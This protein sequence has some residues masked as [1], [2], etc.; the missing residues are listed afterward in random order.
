MPGALPRARCVL[1]LVAS[2]LVTA[3]AAL[4]P[5]G[6]GWEWGDPGTELRWYVSGLD[7]PSTLFQLVGN[8]ALIALPAVFAVRLWPGLRP[9]PR[10]VGASLAA[11]VAI[12]A[13]QFLLP[14]GRVVSPLDALLNASGAVVAA[15]LAMRASRAW[16]AGGGVAPPGS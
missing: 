13:L 5:K 14:I 2:L 9:L 8:L 6:S 16:P 12:E 10:L 7:S 4:R 15:A 11:G 3:V 1:G